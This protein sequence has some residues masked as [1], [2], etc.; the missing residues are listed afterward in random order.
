MGEKVKYHGGHALCDHP[1]LRRW[2]NE[3][4]LVWICPET[5][6]GFPTPRP[7]AEIMSGSGDDVLKATSNVLEDNGRDVTEGYVAGAQAALR[8]ARTH[9][10]RLA[11]LKEESPSCGSEVIYDGSFSGKRKKGRGVTAALLEQNGIRVFSEDRI[12]D[13]E[14]LLKK[15]ES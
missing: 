5:S 4:R 3:G 7:P 13:A 6:A 14:I 1:I 8:T 9:G 2:R 12:E 15:L 10:I 11:I